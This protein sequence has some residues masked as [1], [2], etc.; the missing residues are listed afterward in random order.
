MGTK[1]NPVHKILSS[2]AW[3]SRHLFKVAVIQSSDLLIFTIN[4]II[5]IIIIIII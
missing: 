3:F 1:G 5:I 4:D 2:G